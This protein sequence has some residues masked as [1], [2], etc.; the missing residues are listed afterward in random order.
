MSTRM[1]TFLDKNNATASELDA[2]RR[3]GD[4]MKAAN[5]LT[6]DLWHGQQS[7]DTVFRVYELIER[8]LV[9]ANED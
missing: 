1:E 8:Q 2:I 9:L 7:T 6:F 3:V 5:A 4:L